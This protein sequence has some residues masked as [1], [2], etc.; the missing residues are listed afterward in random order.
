ML[1]GFNDQARLSRTLPASVF[2]AK[3]LGN[4]TD[5]GCQPGFTSTAGLGSAHTL[6]VRPRTFDE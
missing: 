5:L 1:G 3:L 6:Y 2:C 4:V